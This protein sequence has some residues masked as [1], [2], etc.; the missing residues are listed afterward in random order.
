MTADA[1]APAAARED[2][3]VSAAAVAIKYDCVL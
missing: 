1:A 2:S 3:D